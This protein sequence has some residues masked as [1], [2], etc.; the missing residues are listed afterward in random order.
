MAKRKN[1]KPEHQ[2]QLFGF[3]KPKTKIK[4]KAAMLIKAREDMKKGDHQSTLQVLRHINDQ[5]ERFEESI[6][7]KGVQHG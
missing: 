4:L 5:L 7:V 2:F 3:M 1:K 6:Q